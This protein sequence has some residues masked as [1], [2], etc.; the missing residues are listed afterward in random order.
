MDD[1]YNCITSKATGPQNKTRGI[2]STIGQSAPL[3][4]GIS[5]AAAKS[6]RPSTFPDCRSSPCDPPVGSMRVVFV[7]TD[8][9]GAMITGNCADVGKVKAPSCAGR[10]SRALIHNGSAVPTEPV[11]R[12][13]FKSY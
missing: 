7:V 1:P 3:N 8:A 6:P 4:I 2:M 12:E 13:E 9:G 11:V 10:C 5:N